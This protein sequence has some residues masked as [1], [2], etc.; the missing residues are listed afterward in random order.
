MTVIGG[1]FAA[2]LHSQTLMHHHGPCR[3]IGRQI[4]KDSEGW[5]TALP[6][7]P[8]ACHLQPPSRRNC[9]RLCKKVL[10]K[11]VGQTAKIPLE[12]GR[13]PNTLGIHCSSGNPDLVRNT[14]PN[15]PVILDLALFSPGSEDGLAVSF[16]V[17][18]RTSP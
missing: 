17:H 14:S 16:P 4:S 11:Q 12:A 8:R 3:G 15:S 18:Q 9:R 10:R 7:E 1:S 5:V 2:P 6:T 13:V